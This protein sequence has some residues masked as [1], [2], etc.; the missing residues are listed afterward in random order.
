MKKIVFD[1]SSLCYARCFKTTGPEKAIW[2]IS[3]LICVGY[4]RSVKSVFADT[5]CFG[6]TIVLAPP[7]HICFPF[8]DNI[9]FH[10]RLLFHTSRIQQCTRLR[11]TK[12]YPK[13]KSWWHYF[14]K[15]CFEDRNVSIVADFWSICPEFDHLASIGGSSPITRLVAAPPAGRFRRQG[16]RR[17]HLGMLARPTLR[18]GTLISGSGATTPCRAH[19]VFWSPGE[20]QQALE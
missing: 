10:V 13:W 14:W 7:T 1:A 2:I 6:S 15:K 18:N 8:D 19:R 5:N 17:W 9:K 16:G 20:M 3:Q 11:L 4:I 12:I